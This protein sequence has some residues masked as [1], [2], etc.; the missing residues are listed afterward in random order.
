MEIEKTVVSLC[1]TVAKGST[2]AMTDG[3]VI[4][5]DT[6]P[7]ILKVLQVDAEASI[8]DKY[9]ENNRLIISGKVYYKVLYVPDKENERIKSILTTMDF[10]QAADSGGAAPDDGIMASATVQ[11]VEFNAVNSRKLRLRAIIHIDYEICRAKETE[12]CVGIDSDD[13]ECVTENMEFENL[14]DVSSH[15]FTVKER[16]EI[17]SGQNAIGE[18]LKTDVRI[19]DTE[20]KTVMGKII[21][22]GSVG[23]CILYTDDE[24]EIKFTEADIPFTEVLD[25]E[26]VGEDTICDIDYNVLNVMCE[27]EPDSDGDMRIA[28]VDTDISA[29]VRGTDIVNT[30]ILSDCFIPYCDTR[31]QTETVDFVS[32]VYRPYS[33]NTIRE[34]IEFP[35]NAPS[36]G[37]VY[38]VMTNASVSKSE[39]RRD[40]LICEGNIEA[41]ILYLTDSAENPI[42]SVKKDIPFSYMIECENTDGTENAEIK[43]VV[44]HV[45]YNLNSSGDLELRCVLSIEGRLLKN[46]TLTRI[47]D[48]SAQER[49]SRRGI[50]IYFAKDG[51]TI[52]DIAK[53]YSVPQERIIK[54]NDTDIGDI[55]AGS[56]LFIPTI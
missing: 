39:L 5:P 36:V 16:I 13:A 32:T 12:I 42:Y 10:R 56:K 33:Q 48:V 15:A 55:A 19:S 44:N 30:E 21:V 11:R 54:Y 24:G 40:K 7:D 8:T 49:P 6:K 25:A 18:I 3:D 20:H 31:C 1:E 26:G 23:I 14:T 53:H 47:T 28:R 45:S 35:S 37:G 22:K 9:I 46:K 17:P 29:D 51:D 38:N 43:A 4:V 27:A 34:I 2:Q 50:V 52:W 41:Y